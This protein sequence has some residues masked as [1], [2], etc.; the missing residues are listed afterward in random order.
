MR[1]GRIDDLRPV[2]NLPATIALSIIGMVM[3]IM[4]TGK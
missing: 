3:I 4:G 1:R 2:G